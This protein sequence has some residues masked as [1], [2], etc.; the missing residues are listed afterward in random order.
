MRSPR[1]RGEEFDPAEILTSI[2]TL[3]LLATGAGASGT[4][5]AAFI[6]DLVETA[7]T[8]PLPHPAAASTRRCYSRWTR[9]GTSP[10]CPRCRC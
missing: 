3:Y 4:L 9:S 1:V 6:E 7:G 5:V 8:S 10:P 2:A